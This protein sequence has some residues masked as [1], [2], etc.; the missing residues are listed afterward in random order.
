MSGDTT[1]RIEVQGMNCA[2]CAGRA[3]RALGAL[4][5][6]RDVSVNFA[7]GRASM[8]V[9]GAQASDV[10]EALEAANYPAREESVTLSVSGMSCASCV[11]RVEAALKAVPTVL[12]ARANL[13]NETA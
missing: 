8:V 2:A 11:N 10:A 9:Q 1:W 12:D 4:P 6:L 3:E 7:N 5:G 13:A